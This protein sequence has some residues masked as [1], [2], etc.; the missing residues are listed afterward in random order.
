VARR[1]GYTKVTTPGLKELVPLER[2]TV[3]NFNGSR[4]A[5]ADLTGSAAFNDLATR[6]L[7]KTRVT[8]LALVALTALPN[9]STRD[10]AETPITN[11]GLVHLT[12]L[13]ALTVL[14]LRKTRTTDTSTVLLCDGHNVTGTRDG[15]V[16][17][18][19]TFLEPR[20]E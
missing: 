6:D 12:E 13:S 5:G 20:F 10:L 17:T 8:D 3:L 18:G 19:A 14:D 16:G 2:L 7:S 9:L 4:V 11:T 15:P 1:L